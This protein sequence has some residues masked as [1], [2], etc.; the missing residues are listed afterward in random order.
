MNKMPHNIIGSVRGMDVWKQLVLEDHVNVF[1][2]DF[3]D[4]YTDDIS[5]EQCKQNFLEII[6]YKKS[7]PQTILLYGNHELHHLIHGYWLP[8]PVSWN[9][10]VHFDEEHVEEIQQILRDN[11]EHFYGA[12]YGFDNQYLATHAGV[13]DFW[14]DRWIGP[15]KQQKP[16]H[17]AKLI[18]KLW[19]MNPYAFTLLANCLCD[20]AECELEEM[21]WI[22]QSPF[23]I[24]R[25]IVEGFN[26][27]EDTSYTQIIGYT[28]SNKIEIQDKFI[29][30][31][32]LHRATHF[33]P[34][35]TSLIIN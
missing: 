18:N 2:G 32:C 29:Y 16:E 24:V 8:E 4:P 27:F 5:Y 15:Y 22:S 35:I 14:Y 33:E 13:S 30:V 11:K 3:F 10:S 23:S 21:E 1:L 34:G 25:C 19:I 31:D 26:L 9:V 28:Q 6:D 20:Y 17:V 7:H 12:A